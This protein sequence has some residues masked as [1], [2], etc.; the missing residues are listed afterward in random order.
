MS[1]RRECGVCWWVYDPE[2]G[3]DDAGIP[4]GTAFEALPDEYVCPRC[5]AGKV[6]FVRSTASPESD[7][8]LVAKLVTAYRAVDERMRGLAIYNDRLG[9]EAVGFRRAGDALVGAL[10]TPWFL[11]ILVHG[12]SLPAEGESVELALPGGRFR[13]NASSEGEPHLVL[14]LMSPVLEIADPSAAR[15]VA[16]ECL[17]LVLAE[18]EPGARPTAARTMGRRGLLGGLLG[19]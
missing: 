7:D 8:A 18:A 16:R 12:P 6:R 13:F 15:A 1:G 14:P 19:G 2:T 17:R 4:P 3:D 10:V 9:V 5:G 11:S